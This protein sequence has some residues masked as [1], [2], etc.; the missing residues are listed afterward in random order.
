MIDEKYYDLR[1]DRIKGWL[2]TKKFN[3]RIVEL[4]DKWEME[5]KQNDMH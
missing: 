4:L 3:L 2:L 5:V 1:L